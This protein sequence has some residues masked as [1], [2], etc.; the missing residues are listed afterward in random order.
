MIKCNINCIESMGLVDGPGIRT[1]IFLQGCNMRCLYCHNPEMWNTDTIKEYTVEKLMA[2]INRY[3]PYYKD[4]GGITVSGG[5]PLMQSEFL[6]EL[7]KECKKN[8]IST[9]LDTAGVGNN[10]DELL[11]YTDIVLFDI[12][13]TDAIG[14]RN[15]THYEIDES[16]EF[17]NRCNELN[18][19]MWLRQVIIPGMNDNLEYIE[20]LREF[21][22][23]I[24]NVARIEL[25]P[26]HTMGI[27]KYN[28]LSIPYELKDTIA[29]DKDKCDILYNELIKK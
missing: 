10:Y 8:G 4:N 5:E 2:V 27:K 18:K 29:M 17:V 7:F 26:Y 1:V 23:G 15:L 25:L 21:I 19:T 9:C 22:K 11:K 16:L 13:Y 24:N 6:T 20:S 28:D 14:Y 12:K 3:K